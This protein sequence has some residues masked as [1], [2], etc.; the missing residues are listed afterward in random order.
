MICLFWIQVYGVSAAA[1]QQCVLQTALT[2]CVLV[3]VSCLLLPP[4]LMNRLQG[5]RMLPSNPRIKM[6]VEL[7]VIYLSLQ[8]AL[9]AALAVYPQT[10]KFLVSD[11]EPQ[12][13]S[14]TRPD[15][16]P[17]QTLFANKGL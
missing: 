11:L 8:L 5:L 12:F 7:G 9:P 17:I 13:R 3:P 4:F 1:G 6:I 15:G 2:R 10:A 16:S 14:L